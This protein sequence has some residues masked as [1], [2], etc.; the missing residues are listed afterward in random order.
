MRNHKIVLFACLLTGFAILLMAC[1][2]A[3]AVATSAP[4][5]GSS[6]SPDGQTLMQQRC[7]ICHS[8]G[9]VTSQHETADQ[10]RST[11]NR[12]VANGAQLNSREEQTLIDYLAQ[13]YK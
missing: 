9:R 1:G 4:A 6:G 7:S 11:V 3:S 2:T 13:N 5:S 12:M 8:V 10:W